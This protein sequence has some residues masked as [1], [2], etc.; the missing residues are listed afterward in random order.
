M[1]E[2]EM[3][4]DN[5]TSVWLRENR[6]HRMDA[7]DTRG[8]FPRDRQAFHRARYEFALTYVQDLLV[9][10][11]ACGLG[12]GCR[13]LK[14]GGAKRVVGIDASCKTIAYA[15]ST[16]E[17]EGVIF[18]VG[19]ATLAPLANDSVDAI[20]SFETIE[21]ISDT[22]GLLSEFR[23][24]LKARGKLI[25]SSP[26][27]WGLTQYHC[28]TW[29][30]FEFMAEVAAFFTIESVWEQNSDTNSKSGDRSLGIIPWSSQTA[31]LAECLIVVA[32]KS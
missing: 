19:D 18:E 24:V 2:E 20:A 8:I 6:N 27:D 15:R 4:L 29:T 7:L 13:I 30:P 28:H 26:N 23:R 25:I 16:H 14:E 12:Y 5:S 9:A 11:I 21:H 1:P 22:T 3:V 32:R 17:I 10:D 31:K